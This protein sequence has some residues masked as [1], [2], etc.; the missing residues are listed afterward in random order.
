[1]SV[2]EISSDLFSQPEVEEEIGSVF[3]EQAAPEQPYKED[4][5]PPPNRYAARATGEKLLSTAWFSLGSFLVQ[6][7]IDP[8]VGN[9]LRL[10]SPLAGRKIDEAIAGTFIDRIL[11]PIFRKSDDLEGIGVIIALPVMV[12]MY[13][14]NPGMAPV[15]EP[16]MRDVLASTLEQV[17]PLMRAEK[18]KLRRTAR[19]LAD[20]NDAFNIPRGADPI[21]AIM[22]GFIFADPGIPEEE[23]VE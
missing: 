21:D 2:D 17:A 15:L 12:A 14:R 20:I 11:Q 5:K 13:E 18:T 6:R 23:P 19:S 7:R 4:V 22:N 8:P 16:A 9:V 10:Q 3:G 1:M